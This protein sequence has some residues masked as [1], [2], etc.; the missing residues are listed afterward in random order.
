MV[1]VVSSYTPVFVQRRFY[2]GW[3]EE[4]NREVET[5]WRAGYTSGQI[6]KRMNRTRGA[7]MGKVHRLGMLGRSTV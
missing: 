4:E 3:T 6:A 2:R 1:A 5:L 7:I